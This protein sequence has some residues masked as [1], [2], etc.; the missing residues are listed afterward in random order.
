MQAMIFTLCPA[1][2]GVQRGQQLR[3]AA[4]APYGLAVRPFTSRGANSRGQR[5]VGLARAETENQ[6]PSTSQPVGGAEKYGWVGRPGCLSSAGEAGVCQ[7]GVEH[8]AAGPSCPLA[9]Q[10]R[11]VRWR[12]QCARAPTPL[13]A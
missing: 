4:L 11:R 6:E 10:G 8:V 7:P 13:S 9:Q 1:T 2:A 12:R 5:R 3:A